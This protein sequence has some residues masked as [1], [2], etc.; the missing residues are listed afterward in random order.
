MTAEPLIDIRNATV[1]RGEN[2]VF[3][4]LNL[5]ISQGQPT[6]VLGPNGAG[7]T[8]LLKLILREVYPVASKNSSVHVLGRDTWN[9]WELRSQI[10]VVS[11]DL[12][13]R[14][15]GDATGLDVVLSGF[16]SSIGIHGQLS[17]RLGT[18]E[19]ERSKRI[20]AELDISALA[21]TPLASMSTGQQ[22]RCLLARA[23]VHDPASLILD[24][25]TA[26]LDMAASFEFLARIERLSAAGRNIVVVTHLLSEIPPG[27][28]RVIL[29]ANGSVVADGRKKEVLTAGNLSSAYG[30]GIRVAVV[31][32]HYLAVPASANDSS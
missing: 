5:A 19:I 24:E 8:T 32:G 17:G 1:Y 10:G 16:L 28:E 21:D 20:L 9:V 31:D 29:L 14:Y 15:R 30:T 2:R 27:I 22:R 6:A 3:H 4:N 13:M 25:P 7:K 26:G 23:L 11:H 18:A 12:Q